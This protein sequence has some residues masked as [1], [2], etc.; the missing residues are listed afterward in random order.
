M[1]SRLG[2]REHGGDV[3]SPF[4]TAGSLST[5]DTGVGPVLSILLSRASCSSSSSSASRSTSSIV[6]PSGAFVMALAI[7]SPRE[8]CSL[9]SSLCSVSRCIPSEST[10]YRKPS[11][12]HR[13]GNK[14]GRRRGER[15][16]VGDGVHSLIHHIDIQLAMDLLHGLARALHRRQ[17]LVER[18]FVLLLALQRRACRCPKG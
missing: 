15:G 16:G 18:V 14:E 13:R 4:A 10:E 12:L 2:A 9:R 7:S 6:S 1:F 8:C 5:A 17:R 11:P 3:H